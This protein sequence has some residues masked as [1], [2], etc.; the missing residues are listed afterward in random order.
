MK[1]I[2]DALTSFIQS[3]GLIAVF[4]LMTAESCLIPIPSEITM[5]FAG[6]MAAQGFMSF[7]AVVIVGAVGNLVGSLLAYRLGA[8]K[9][10]P[11]VRTAIQKWGKYLLV[12]ES[13]FNK[14]KD[15]LA[16]Y[17]S[18]VAFVSRLLPIVRT[19]VSLPAGIAKT[20]L[21][22]FSIL[23]FIGSLLWSTLL[24]WLGW[25]LGQN[26][27]A[28]EPWF[29]KFQYVILVLIVLAVAFY[30]WSHLKRRGEP[31]KEDAVTD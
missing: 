1:E 19:F 2:A 28:I 22:W 17:G 9:G 10:E 8:A 5:P 15:W 6:F 11:W 26:W 25:T 7:P 12:K 30:I 4:I 24:A 13:D 14:G 27:T 16:R 23:T 29:R 18:P 3:Y 21:A 31:P 20:N